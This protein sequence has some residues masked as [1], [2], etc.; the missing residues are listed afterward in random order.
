MPSGREP[1]EGSSLIP[2]P[3][4]PVPLL[5]V[6]GEED[7]IFSSGAAAALRAAAWRER[8]IEIPGAGHLPHQERPAETLRILQE[9]LVSV[10]EPTD[11]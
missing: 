5:L 2:S 7:R 3:D 6:R 4:C 11:A 9:F 8:L 10:E 1:G